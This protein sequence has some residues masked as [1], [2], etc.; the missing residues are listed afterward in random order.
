MI[1]YDYQQF[2]SKISNLYYNTLDF[3]KALSIN[4][5]VFNP[6]NNDLTLNIILNRTSSVLLAETVNLPSNKWSDIEL[7]INR[8]LLLNDYNITDI[9][10]T[11][12]DKLNIKDRNFIVY[13]D[14]VYFINTESPIDL[15]EKNFQSGEILNF[16][17]I[18]DLSYI[19]EAGFEVH[20]LNLT[21]I[22]TSI[23][24]DSYYSK[25]GYSLK[26]EII[27]N[28]SEGSWTISR[29]IEKHG[30]LIDNILLS[31]I[32]ITNASRISVDIY[33]DH[34]MNKKFYLYLA[35]SS[36]HNIETSCFINSKSW[37]TITASNLNQLDLTKLSSI[38]VL[39]ENF[40]I[41][42]NYNIYIDNLNFA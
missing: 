40:Q 36:G 20:N 19:N 29:V 26:A 23:N 18:A 33:N 31:Q 28:N 25:S 4:L 22:K 35:D 3:T 6:N 15:V 34:Y 14:N 38:Y 32:N 30:I 10:L 24:T 39:Y 5:S 7:Y 42:E 27:K 17:S 41:F 2:T 1:C 11:F 8:S 21:S 37:G 13:V 12:I 16:D 9:S